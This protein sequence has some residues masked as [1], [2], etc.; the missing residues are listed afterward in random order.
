VLL[1]ASPRPVTVDSL[2]DAIWGDAP[3]ASANG[4]LQTYVSRLRRIVEPAGGE[5]AFDETGYRLVVDPDDVDLHRFERLADRGHALLGDAQP[6][7]AR[8][9]LLEADA[10]WRGPVL[11]DLV[12]IEGMLALSTRLEERRL[13]L[14][15]GSPPTCCSVDMRR[16]A[17]SPKW[18]HCIRSASATQLRAPLGAK[19]ARWARSGGL[20]VAGRLGIEPSRQLRS[21]IGDL[22]RPRPRAPDAGVPAANVPANPCSR[23]AS[24]QAATPAGLSAA[25]RGPT[26]ASSCSGVGDRQ[27][28]ARRRGRGSLS[29]GSGGAWGRVTSGAARA[30]A[31]FRPPDARW[32]RWGLGSTQAP[33]RIQVDEPVRSLQTVADSSA[34]RLRHRR[35][36]SCWTTCSGRTTTRSLLGFLAH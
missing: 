31:G 30:L 10:L 23:R 26:R 2:I 28:Q 25:L 32:D 1:A 27:D 29:V 36:S 6:A 8:E 16:S 19:P 13:A 5:L 34:R 21:R 17:D 9:L 4:T 35:W 33:R 14:E 12:Y 11:A 24:F 18:S 20:D 3:P 22:P 7:A 15:V